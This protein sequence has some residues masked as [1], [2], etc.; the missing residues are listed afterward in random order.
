M[1]F[2]QRFFHHL[3]TARQQ[4]SIRFKQIFYNA[5]MYYVLPV[6]LSMTAAN[7][8]AHA[9]FN[10]K[11][12]PIEWMATAFGVTFLLFPFAYRFLRK[13]MTFN[14]ERYYMLEALKQTLE[15]SQQEELPEKQ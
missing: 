4:R 1:D 15:A 9:F 8:I 3:G 14:R 11:S 5:R 2:E 12:E 10:G 6:V 7:F 13:D